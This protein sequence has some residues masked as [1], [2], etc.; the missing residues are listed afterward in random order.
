MQHSPLSR[1]AFSLAMLLLTLALGCALHATPRE[2]RAPA[3]APAAPRTSDAAHTWSGHFATL[4]ERARAASREPARPAPELELPPSL[5]DVDW[6]TYRTIRYLPE[7]SLWRGQPGHF[8]AQFFHLGF[9]YRTPVSMFVLDGERLEQLPFAADRFSYDGLAP[10]PAGTTLGYAGLRLHTN[11]NSADY[12]DELIVFQGASY[13][14]AVG[15]GDALGLSARALAVDTGESSPE[16][17][18][19][20]S[21]LYLVRP[22]PDARS[23]WVLGLLDSQRVT[24]ACAFHIQPADATVIDV[25]LRVFVREPVKLLGLAPFSSMYL[26]G[27]ADPHRFGDARPEV[28]DSDGVAIATAAGE[29]IFRPL[30]NPQRT[31]VTEYRLD[32][33]RGFGLVQRDRSRESYRPADA[34]A[35]ADERYQ[36]RPSAW[37]EPLGDW[38]PGKLRLLEIAT[39]LES[40]DNVALAWVPDQLPRDGLSVRYRLRFGS[41]VEGAAGF[42]HVLGTRL[43][44]QSPGRAR[45][46]VDFRV[47]GAESLK[48]PV[49]LE[50]STSQGELL[51]RQVV[52]DPS[53]HGFRVSFD[54]QRNDPGRELE[55]RAFLRAGT[56]VLTETWSY[57]WQAKS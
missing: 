25:E 34:R 7:R 8:E 36:D 14:R 40:D 6:N 50:L 10:P 54:V 1:L 38:G 45:F 11:L 41:A 18:P 13:F 31:D 49:E 24:G 17:F 29:R 2:A 9:I 15:R 19:R 3:L 35:A 47:P 20:F 42:G 43:H 55:L 27:E 48:Q 28:H 21:E 26:F 37:V 53:T 23:V 5:R 22:E 46:E 44:E 16:E 56:D 33:P 51:S 4:V 52:P 30:R 57:S 32:S 39:A 12:R